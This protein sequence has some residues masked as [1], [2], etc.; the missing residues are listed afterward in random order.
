VRLQAVEEELEKR[1]D[2][3]DTRLKSRAHRNRNKFIGQCLDIQA[4][5]A[6]EAGEIGYMANMLVQATLPHSKQSGSYFKRKNGSLTIELMSS[7]KGLPYGSYPRLL[8]A[9]LTTQVCRNEGPQIHLGESLTQFMA[10][11]GLCAT[12]G[13]WGSISNL[14]DQAARLF[15]SDIVV[16]DERKSAGQMQKLSVAEEYVWWERA[17]NTQQGTFES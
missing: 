3:I 7:S 15:S 6:R 12:G 17:N 9:W 5:P 10:E 14:K 13:R 8:M 2:A 1:I 16:W 4:K 11:L